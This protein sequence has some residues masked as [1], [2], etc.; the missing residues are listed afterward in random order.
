MA[1]T[2]LTIRDESPAGGTL[3]ELSV[4]FLTETI[5]VRDLIRGR[6]Y[7]E[8]QD[9]NLKTHSGEPYRGLVRPE[10]IEQALNGPVARGRA[11]PIDWKAQFDRAV[12][13]FERQQ[14]LILIDDRQAGSLDETFTIRSATTVSF[15]RLTLLVGG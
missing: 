11:R 15:L 2:T 7:Q 9:Y 10:P 13:A 12:E 6:V 5:T 1:T 3:N 14:I 4:D 8:V